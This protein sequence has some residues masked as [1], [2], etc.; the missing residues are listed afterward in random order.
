MSEITLSGGAFP[1]LEVAWVCAPNA[2]GQSVTAN[3]SPMV[4][5]L[6]TVVNNTASGSGEVFNGIVVA[7]NQIQNVPLGQYIYEIEIP[8]ID[9]VAS[10]SYHQVISYFRNITDNSFIRRSRKFTAHAYGGIASMSGQFKITA[11]KF[12]DV[13]FSTSQGGLTI[14]NNGFSNFTTSTAGEDQRTTVKLWKVA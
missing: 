7:S 2:V 8:Y 1:Y 4:C 6:D 10:L 11:S 14:G 3:A 12:L 9:L 13:R 5:T